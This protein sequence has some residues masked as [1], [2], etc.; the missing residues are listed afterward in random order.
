MSRKYKFRDDDKL[1][2]VTFAVVNWI[3]LF[4]RNE[5]R[6]IILDSIKYCQQNKSLEVYGWCI[7]TSHVHLMIGS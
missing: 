1:Y 4:V 6:T 3:D 5:Y 7:M 2:F